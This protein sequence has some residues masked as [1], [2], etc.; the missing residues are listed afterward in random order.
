MKALENKWVVGAL[1]AVA[2]GVLV[3]QLWP[4][5][6]SGSGKAGGKSGS[7]GGQ[8]AAPSKTATTTETAAA[9]PVVT[10]QRPARQA[11]RDYFL[12]R[13]VEWR[14]APR[15]DPFELYPKVKA[16]PPRVE[17]VA[18]DLLAL[19][20]V[21]RQSGGSLV[22]VNDRVL[23]V[24]DHIGAYRVESIGADYIW[25]SGPNGRER[26]RFGRDKS[27][28]GTNRVQQAQLTP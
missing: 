21:W 5:S 4:S 14:D 24:R 22:V 19:T 16:M 11:N 1:G 23:G 6:S 12:S 28:P 13:I 27:R 25:V 26:V 18:D 2:V 15:R 17:V 10:A 7:Q 3:L 8:K 9:P 20:A